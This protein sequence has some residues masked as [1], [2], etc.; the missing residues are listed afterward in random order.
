MSVRR[1][2]YSVKVL[3][4]LL[5]VDHLLAVPV[6]WVSVKLLLSDF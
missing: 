5:S 6:V 1:V 4:K 3:N 2:D